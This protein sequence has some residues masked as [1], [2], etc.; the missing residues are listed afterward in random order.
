M[1]Y[2]E[3]ERTFLIISEEISHQEHKEREEIS[4]RSFDTKIISPP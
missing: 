4:P 3:I 1:I 2:K